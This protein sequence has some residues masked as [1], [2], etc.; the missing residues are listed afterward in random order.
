M[1]IQL[2]ISKTKLNCSVRSPGYLVCPNHLPWGRDVSGSGS[3]TK[4]AAMLLGSEIHVF[5]PYTG[6]LLSASVE[7]YNSM[8]R[9]K[10]VVYAIQLSGL[11]LQLF[12]VKPKLYWNL[13]TSWTCVA[14]WWE[15]LEIWD[16]SDEL[17]T[18]LLLTWLFSVRLLIQLR[19][20]FLHTLLLLQL[21]ICASVGRR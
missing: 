4:S 19:M 7:V 21:R 14:Y 3:R 5:R 9:I 15:L 8:R 10:I 20:P 16:C 18:T 1:V 6:I 12:K 13:C 11:F 2:N 17:E